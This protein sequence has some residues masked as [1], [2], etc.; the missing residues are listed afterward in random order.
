MNLAVGQPAMLGRT[1]GF[2]QEQTYDPPEH[3][4]EQVPF[5]FQRAC[6]PGDDEFGAG[7]AIT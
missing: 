4:F 5:R 7:R 6:V 2:G 1:A 3:T